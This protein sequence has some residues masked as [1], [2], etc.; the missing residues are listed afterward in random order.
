MTEKNIEKNI[1]ITNVVKTYVAED[2]KE[3]S[4]MD[5]CVTYEDELFFS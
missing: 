2:G 4:N 1:E 3:F 5:K